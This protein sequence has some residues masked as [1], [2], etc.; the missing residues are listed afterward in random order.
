MFDRKKHKF[1]KKFYKMEFDTK[2]FTPHSHR[3]LLYLAAIV[4]VCITGYFGAQDLGIWRSAAFSLWVFMG[5]VGLVMFS[6]RDKPRIT[7]VL[8]RLTVLFNSAFLWLIGPNGFPLFVVFGSII[9]YVVVFSEFDLHA[10]KFGREINTVLVLIFFTSIMLG[11]KYPIHGYELEYNCATYLVVMVI[12]LASVLLL[13]NIVDRSLANK[14]LKLAENETLLQS[15]A[16]YTK[17]FSMLVHSIK[18]SLLVIEQRIEIAKLKNPDSEVVPLTHDGASIITAKTKE[19]FL[20]TS[21]FINAQKSTIESVSTKRISLGKLLDQEMANLGYTPSLKK[22]ANQSSLKLIQPEA[23][24]IKHAL[25]TFVENAHIYSGKLPVIK[26]QQEEIT[27]YDE[28]PGLTVQQAESFG[29]SIMTSS[30]KSGSGIGVYLSFNMLEMMGW[31]A[32]LVNFTNGLTIT[33][34]KNNR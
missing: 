8:L 23:Y 24:A 27:I 6:Q 32:H 13:R 2:Y 33:I 16:W 12:N 26:L 34:S 25:K 22:L 30:R 7:K 5:L 3:Q 1:K 19:M 17:S 21:E 11:P 15:Q 18:N 9:L 28:G 29:K 14:K 4:L 20:M 10:E 31:K